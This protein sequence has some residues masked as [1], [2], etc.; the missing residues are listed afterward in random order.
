MKENM[1]NLLAIVAGVI[2]VSIGVWYMRCEEVKNF[3]NGYCIECG[4]KYEAI[5]H[6]H[7]RTYYECPSC[8]F[9]CYH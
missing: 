5:N 7:G 1:L 9:G 2:V 4:T 8:Y 3:N 6:S